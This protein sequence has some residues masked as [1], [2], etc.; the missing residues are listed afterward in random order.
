MLTATNAQSVEAASAKTSLT[1]DFR[2]HFSK[3]GHE[4]EQLF[5]AVITMTILS[6]VGLVLLAATAIYE[7][8]FERKGK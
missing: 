2:S 3:K 1:S 6:A 5:D 8:F 4:M 7:A